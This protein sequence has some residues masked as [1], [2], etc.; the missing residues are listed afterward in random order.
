MTPAAATS[1]GQPRLLELQEDDYAY[2]TGSLTLRVEEID[3]HA[4]HYAGDVWH[5]VRG[6]RIGYAGREIGP[7][8]VLV[9]RRRL[10]QRAG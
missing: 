5:S 2:G 4:V 3:H 8:Q 9:R 1:Q 10:Q 7:L 6:I